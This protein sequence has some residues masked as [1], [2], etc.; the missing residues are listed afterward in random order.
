MW[1]VGIQVTT[2][3]AIMT[4]LAAIVIAVIPR[5]TLDARNGLTYVLSSWHVVTVCGPLP[6]LSPAA[7]EEREASEPSGVRMTRRSPATAETARR[8]VLLF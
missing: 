5:S 7:D 6:S 4:I 8:P 2:L 1:P 3:A